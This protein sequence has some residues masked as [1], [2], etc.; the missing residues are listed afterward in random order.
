MI[1]KKYRILI[2]DPPWNQGK[3]GKRKARP[4]QST[5]LDQPTMKKNELTSLPINEWAD[6]NCFLWLW[7]TNS[8]DKETGEFVETFSIVTTAAN[9]LMEQIHNSKKRMPT[10]L[11][12]DL[13]WEWLFGDLDEERISEIARYQFPSEQMEAFTISKNFRSALEPASP[14]SYDL[15]A[16]ELV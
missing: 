11:T 8:K 6:K 10:I 13:A 9:K 15:P 3:T 2:I 16:L 4:N 12:D 7:A 1:N 5:R 14:I